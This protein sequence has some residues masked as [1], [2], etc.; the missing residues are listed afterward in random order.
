[1]LAIFLFTSA[2]GSVFD[3]AFIPLSVNPLFL[4]LYVTV[5][6]IAAVAA[7]AFWFLYRHYNNEDD[8]MNSLDKTSTNLPSHEQKASIV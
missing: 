1:V 8:E 7:I 4:W 2:I 6:A 5:L 3:Q